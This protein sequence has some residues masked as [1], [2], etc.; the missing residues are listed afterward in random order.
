MSFLHLEKRCARFSVLRN[1]HD[2]RLIHCRSGQPFAMVNKPFS[3]NRLHLVLLVC[4][5]AKAMVVTLWHRVMSL[6]RI[7]FVKWFLGKWS[8]VILFHSCGIIVVV[9]ISA[10]DMP[11][12][13]KAVSISRKAIVYPV[14]SFGA[15]RIRFGLGVGEFMVREVDRRLFSALGFRKLEIRRLCL[16]S[17]EV[18]SL[19]RD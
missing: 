7:A 6:W 1:P 14:M 10:F 19:C 13:F 15:D 16:I 9:A 4:T 3:V 8:P 2:S 18:G 17:G 11:L 5:G 12:R